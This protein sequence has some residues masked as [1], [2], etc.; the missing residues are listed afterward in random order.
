M[1]A[2]KFK[3]WNGNEDLVEILL[4]DEIKG[5]N[6][7][8]GY[9]NDTL[10][11]DHEVLTEQK[12]NEVINVACTT[13]G[14]S[15]EEESVLLNMITS[16]P[17]KSIDEDN[18]RMKN[19]Q[20]AQQEGLSIEY[21][22]PK[23]RS[24]TSCRRSF[25]TERVSLR[26]EAEDQMIWD[27]VEIDWENRRIM[28]YLP[29]RGEEEEF[30]SSNR[31]IALKILDQQCLLYHK[32]EETKDLIVKAFAKLL[33]NG[34]MVFW[35]DLNED[36][37]R[38]IEAKAVQHYIPW[39]VSFKASISTPARPV[40]D[41]STNTKHREDGSGGR[42]LN[43]AV[44]KGRVVTLNLIKMVL[45]FQIGP[46][47]MQGDLKQF[48][49]SIKLNEDQFNLQRILYKEDL[50][51]DSEVKEAVIKTLIWG[52][53]CVSAQSECAVIKLAEAVKDKQPL[54]ADFLVN[55][56]FVDDLSASGESL[57]TLKQLSKEAD[58]V[59][60]QVGLGCKGWKLSA[61]RC[62]RGR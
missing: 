28:C 47:A 33:K 52:V 11:V 45:R 14:V 9:I 48:Y 62:C 15:I 49:A 10:N 39:R 38:I 2:E 61:S 29:L 51:P 34:Q 57:E 16:L 18:F 19:L 54:L 31:D 41:A 13:C 1:F 6:E 53:K 35:N 7:G 26:E 5:L 27:S 25:E 60:S 8:I 4:N 30:L 23:C 32:D 59:F 24:C 20:K 36:E 46:E 42:C 56:R 21:R 43:D 37:K 58:E 55:G 12:G 50:N 3:E 22:C 44:V 17:A 40:M